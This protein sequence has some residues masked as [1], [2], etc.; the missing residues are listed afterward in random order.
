ML[1]Y[2]LLS[3]PKQT[4]CVQTWHFQAHTNDRLCISK[5]HRG[6]TPAWSWRT[7]PPS[8]GIGQPSVLGSTRAL[9]VWVRLMLRWSHWTC[10]AGLDTS[11]AWGAYSSSEPHCWPCRCGPGP[12]TCWCQSLASTT[13]DVKTFDSTWWSQAG[14]SACLCSSWW[15]SER[16]VVDL[17]SLVQ[18]NLG[19]CCKPA[20]S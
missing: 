1:R 16:L 13:L 15:A 11:W 2:L 10:T 14:T 9:S 6:E 4:L 17:H 8:L 7:W 5:A 20:S 3:S 18:D 19:T 12:R